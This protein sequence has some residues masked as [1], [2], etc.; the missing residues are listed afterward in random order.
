MRADI[1]EQ[2]SLRGSM[3]TAAQLGI[4]EDEEDNL[5]IEGRYV[6]SVDYAYDD[7]SGQIEVVFGTDSALSDSDSSAQMNIAPVSNNPGNGW[8]CEWE[9]D[10]T[11]VSW[12]PA[13]CRG[14]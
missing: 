5:G 9:G 4:G 3:P 6:D 12:L 2:Y 11:N 14:D 13:G 1:A 10:S 7:G 8:I